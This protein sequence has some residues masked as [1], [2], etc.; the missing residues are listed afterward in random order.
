M[1]NY[2]QTGGSKPS[3]TAPSR[4]KASLI[5]VDPAYLTRLYSKDKKIDFSGYL[6]ADIAISIGGG[7]SESLD[8]SLTRFLPSAIGNTLDTA[9]QL[10]GVSSRTQAL[11]AKTWDSPSHLS[12]SLPITLDAY[13]DTVAEVM[14]PMLELL[15][16]CAPDMSGG[17]MQSP[18][19]TPAKA[20][21][22]AAKNSA[23]SGI[24]E[25]GEALTKMLKGQILTVTVGKFFKMTPVVVEQASAQI[26]GLMEVGTGNPIRVV[27]TLEV[28]S[29]F[30]VTKDDL[31]AFF[32]GAKDTGSV[33]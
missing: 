23:T 17:F 8:G 29:Y 27:V 18:G 15:K 6:P 7:W 3:G 13:S 10:L 31:E 28:S 2:L 4:S 32:I 26:K 21:V 16:L 22:E 12:L 19:P 20:L 30:A 5:N 24:S 25:T 9:G 1:A 14:K 11:T 33:T